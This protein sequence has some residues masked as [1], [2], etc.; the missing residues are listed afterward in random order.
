MH[1]IRADKSCGKCTCW[2]LVKFIPSIVQVVELVRVQMEGTGKAMVAGLQSPYS[3]RSTWTGV[4]IFS[5]CSPL[6]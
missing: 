3:K 1:P 5:K 6:K 2:S 4:E